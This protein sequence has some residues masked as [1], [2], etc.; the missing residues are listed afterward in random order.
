MPI[1]TVGQ[2]EAVSPTSLIIPF[3]IDGKDV[4]LQE[5]E[6]P[7]MPFPFA[8]PVT[9]D[10]VKGLQFADEITNRA[11]ERIIDEALHKYPYQKKV[12]QIWVESF[13]ANDGK[14]KGNLYWRFSN[15][16]K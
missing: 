10:I 11:A 7:P 2:I 12:V 4:Q 16:A 8:A 5:N 3:A 6:T 15:D 13:G 1:L 9:D 14:I